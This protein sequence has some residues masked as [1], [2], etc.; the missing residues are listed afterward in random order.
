MKNKISLFLIIISLIF[1]FIIFY[2]GLSKTTLYE[3]ESRIQNIPEFTSVT[4]FKKE[5][6]N[7]KKIF[8]ETDF[9]LL[10]IWASW[11]LPCRDEHPLLM[12][13]NKKSE[14]KIIGLNYK[15]VSKNAEKFLNELGNPYDEILV[16]K[17]GT[18]AIEWGAF[19]VPESFLIH[20]NKIK[21]KFIGPLNIKSV[22]EIKKLLK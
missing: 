15:D 13:L 18:I 11:C 14:L 19:G 10:N 16:D 12:D 4:F 1:V 20:K 2:K 9:Y 21:K 5:E 7:P 6:T 3:P 22:E 17:N 8:N